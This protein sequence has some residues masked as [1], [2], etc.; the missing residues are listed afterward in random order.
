MDII[1]CTNVTVGVVYI[2]YVTFGY[3]SAVTLIPE[4]NICHILFHWLSISAFMIG[5]K[6]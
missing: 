3:I 2:S 1:V 4:K 6:K 5:V